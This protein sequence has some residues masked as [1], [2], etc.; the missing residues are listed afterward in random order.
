VTE[1]LEKLL[2][3]A[4]YCGYKYHLTLQHATEHYR[5]GQRDTRSNQKLLTKYFAEWKELTMA[6]IK[7]IDEQCTGV[8]DYG[9]PQ[10]SHDGQETERE[11]LDPPTSPETGSEPPANPLPD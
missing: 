5:Q 7:L 6:A 8:P 11:T 9:G 3:R 4:T 1:E 10:D 2:L